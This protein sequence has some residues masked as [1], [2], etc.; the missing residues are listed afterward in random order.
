M[1]ESYRE[2]IWDIETLP[3]I[4]MV[5]GL[6]DQNISPDNIIVE[7]SIASIAWTFIDAKGKI[8]K[9]QSV[10]ILDD[11][12]R[13]DNSVYDDFYVIDKFHPILKEANVL[14]GH[15]GDNFDLK[16]FNWRAR[17]NGFKPTGPK[18]TVDTLKESRKVFKAP[19]HRLD[20]KGKAHGVG[21]KH[22]AGK[23]GLQFII[24]RYEV[25]ANY[26]AKAI[27]AVRELEEYNI[28]DVELL[29]EVYK[30]ERVYYKRRPNIQKYVQK[31]GICPDC[32][33]KLINNGTRA[34][35]QS[36]YQRYR[37]TSVACS[38]EFRDKKP[39]FTVDRVK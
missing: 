21:G 25:D 20:Y 29:H 16:V 2:L 12:E 34:V 11:I 9:I 28:R 15:N 10:S 22:E 18:E 5:Y 3:S 26:R 30:E 31:K 1:D 13:F 33:S 32:G 23:K 38:G 7:S 35:G 4:V 36:V 27:T 6:Y 19:S 39:L 14:V 8:D 37:C 17:I 24:S